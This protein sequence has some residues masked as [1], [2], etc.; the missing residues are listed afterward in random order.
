[1]LGVER[2][3]KFYPT[4][5]NYFETPEERAVARERGEEPCEEEEEE[6]EEG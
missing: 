5:H 6:E 1:M 4:K 2:R 3:V